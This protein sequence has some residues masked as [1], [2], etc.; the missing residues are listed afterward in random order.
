MII[1]VVI[2]FI[3]IIIII[4]IIR[5]EPRL[6]LHVI[7]TAFSKQTPKAKRTLNYVAE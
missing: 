7:I 4:I 1:V 5:T 2:I 6:L 3:I